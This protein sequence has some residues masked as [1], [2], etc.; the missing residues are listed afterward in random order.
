[1]AQLPVI[2][3]LADQDPIETQE[4]V[5]ALTAVIE[6]E[7]APR[8]HYLIESMIATAREMGAEIPYS[9]TTEYIN[10]IPPEQQPRYPGD[11]DMEIRIHSH[12]RWN[13]MAMVVRANKHT[14]VGGHIASFASAAALYDVG[15]AHFWKAPSSQSGGDLIFSQAIPYRA[16]TRA[17]FFSGA[18]PKNN[19]TTSARKRA[20]KASPPIR[21]PG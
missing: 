5:D 6:K 15:F 19:S 17:R 14:N 12:I 9:A 18:S 13:A 11:P 10:T 16:F 20:G 4:W 21:T 7:G 2:P 1:M 3:H 8:A